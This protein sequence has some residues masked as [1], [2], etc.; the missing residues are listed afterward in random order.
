MGVGERARESRMILLED[1]RVDP[2]AK[3]NYAIRRALRNGHTDVI[4]LLLNDGRA[5]VAYD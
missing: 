3:H 1:D 5:N 2:A 4:E